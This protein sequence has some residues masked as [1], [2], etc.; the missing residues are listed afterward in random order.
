VLPGIND[1]Y[2]GSKPDIGAIETRVVPVE[3]MGFGIE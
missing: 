2:I 1:G 3:L